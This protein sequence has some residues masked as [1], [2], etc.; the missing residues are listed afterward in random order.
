MTTYFIAVLDRIVALSN[1]Q[2]ITLL[3]LLG[4]ATWL[5]FRARIFAFIEQF[6]L[7]RGN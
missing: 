2:A 3:V 4:V 6:K 1:I 5:T 7:D